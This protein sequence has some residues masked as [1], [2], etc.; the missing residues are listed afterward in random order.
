MLDFLCLI[1]FP[2][3]GLGIFAYCFYKL[4]L[5]EEEK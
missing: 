2:P 4:F 1:I 3:L 5:E